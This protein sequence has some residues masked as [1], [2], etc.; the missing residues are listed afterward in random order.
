MSRKIM[1]HSE[2]LGL[3]CMGMPTEHVDRDTAIRKLADAIARTTLD[4]LSTE[5]R[6]KPPIT[7]NDHIA[8]VK[9]L[10]TEVLFLLNNTMGRL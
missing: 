7:I 8:A 10:T 2:P 5:S 6:G 3:D 4:V 9:I 1:S